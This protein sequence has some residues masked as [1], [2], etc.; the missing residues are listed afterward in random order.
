MPGTSM[1]TMKRAVFWPVDATKGR[2][3]CKNASYE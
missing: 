2:E 1:E 3:N